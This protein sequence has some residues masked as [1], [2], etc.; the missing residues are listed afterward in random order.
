MHSTASCLR[1]PLLLLRNSAAICGRSL[2][3]S[4][5]FGIIAAHHSPS[6][7]IGLNGSLPF[8]VPEDRKYFHDVTH[9]CV[10]IMGRH[11]FN[12]SGIHLPH[13]KATI[14]ISRSNQHELNK[15]FDGV[16]EVEVVSD[17]GNA[18]KAAFRRISQDD[19]DEG[20]SRHPKPQVWV[21]GG[22]AIYALALAHPRA[23]E[24]HLT[25]IQSNCSSFSEIQKSTTS[26]AAYFPNA[27]TWEQEGWN[28]TSEKE[29]DHSGVA[30]VGV[31]PNGA[32]YRFRV[33]TRRTTS[34]D[35]DHTTIRS[36]NTTAARESSSNIFKSLTFSISTNASKTSPSSW[37]TASLSKLIELNGG[38]ILPTISP[39]R[40]HSIITTQGARDGLTGKVRKAR[41][42]GVRIIDVEWITKCIE[43]G[44]IIST[45]NHEEE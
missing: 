20:K 7:L 23:S 6:N 25:E 35:N 32:T 31:I 28:I 36:S 34:D 5:S 29:G 39:N 9:Q 38:R 30:D 27:R 33:Y 10:L 41:K 12:E 8:I 15:R 16:N 14:I 40:L 22:S 3:S 21:V 1:P 11:T 19:D 26:A 37:N 4:S 2:S 18:L 42:R 43:A 17:F 13:S 44:G 24:L 45:E